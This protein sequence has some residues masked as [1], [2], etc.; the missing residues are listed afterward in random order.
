M[1]AETKAGKKEEAEAADTLTKRCSVITRRNMPKQEKQNLAQEVIGSVGG[2]GCIIIL[3]FLRHTSSDS[4]IP[5]KP[6]M[7]FLHSL[8]LRY[9]C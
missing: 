5:L 4:T 6:V 9:L 7:S 1:D 2:I 8:L 3:L